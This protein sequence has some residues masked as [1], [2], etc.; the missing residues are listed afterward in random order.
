METALIRERK[1]SERLKS[2]ETQIALTVET[3][4]Q[5][6]IEY[7]KGVG[8]YIDVLTALTDEQRLRRDR[9]SAQMDLIEYRIDLYRALAGGF[10]P[11][12]DY[13]KS[14]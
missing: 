14:L 12:K 8:N 1:Q 2:I 5:L 10:E 3:Y 9:L 6:R 11:A 13:V 4:R 7:F